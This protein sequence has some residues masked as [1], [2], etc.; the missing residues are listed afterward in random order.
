[1]HPAITAENIVFIIAVALA[2][3][4]ITIFIYIIKIINAIMLVLKK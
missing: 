3:V 2:G 1:M 4:V